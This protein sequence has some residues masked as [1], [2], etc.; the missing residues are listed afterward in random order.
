MWFLHENGNKAAVKAGTTGTGIQTGA[1]LGSKMGKKRL[2]C[3][4]RS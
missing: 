3:W 1:L 2:L 4:F